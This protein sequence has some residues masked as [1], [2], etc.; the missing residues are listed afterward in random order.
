[1]TVV[2]AHVFIHKSVKLISMALKNISVVMR[3]Y[4]FIAVQPYELQKISAHI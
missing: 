2:Y 1:M 4:N 3:I